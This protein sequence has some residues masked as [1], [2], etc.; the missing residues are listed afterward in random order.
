[1]TPNQG[2]FGDMRRTN[3]LKRVGQDPRAYKLPLQV[4]CAAG[5]FTIIPYTPPKAQIDI[6]C[7]GLVFVMLGNQDRLVHIRVLLALDTE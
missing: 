5:G 1:M 4:I 7:V 2:I 3:F 6:P